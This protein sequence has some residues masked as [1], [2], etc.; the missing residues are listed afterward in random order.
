MTARTSQTPASQLLLAQ[1]G[2]AQRKSS[3]SPPSAIR[4]PESSDFAQSGGLARVVRLPLRES[5][6]TVEVAVG[7]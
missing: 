4:P 6:I 2:P 5:M 1:F 3:S 7:W